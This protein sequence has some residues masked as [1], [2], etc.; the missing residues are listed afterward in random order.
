MS[1]IYSR[2]GM[3]SLNAMDVSRLVFKGAIRASRNAAPAVP[4]VAPQA[5]FQNAV[6]VEPQFGDA[7]YTLGT[8][9]SG[10]VGLGEA[11]SF[12][13]VGD[14]GFN[15]AWSNDD[16]LNAQSGWQDRIRSAGITWTPPAARILDDANAAFDELKAAAEESDE[17]DVLLKKLRAK[18]QSTMAAIDALT[19]KG[20]IF[21]HRSDGEER[22]RVAAFNR[23]KKILNEWATVQIPAAPISSRP[24]TAPPAVE[25]IFPVGAS[26]IRP[27]APTARDGRGTAT[28]RQ[29]QQ[30]RDEKKFPLAPVLAGVGLLAVGGL[31]YFMRRK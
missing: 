1:N 31:V 28:M 18:T 14:L 17:A 3:R 25:D 2:Y 29:G 4:R 30:G 20:D 12:K 21:A 9:V 27:R 16:F 6:Q 22:Q 10:F 8:G 5:F 15:E 11:N 13:I 19:K 7:P 26:P 23:L 24:P